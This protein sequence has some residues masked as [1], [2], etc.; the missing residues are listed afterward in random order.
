[1]RLD[2][3]VTQNVTLWKMS[4]NINFRMNN[5]VLP[6][7]LPVPISVKFK[8]KS[9]VSR[10]N[11]KMLAKRPK[12]CILLMMELLK[13]QKKLTLPKLF[14]P[15]HCAT[16]KLRPCRKFSD[17]KSLAHTPKLSSKNLETLFDQLKIG[18]LF[19]G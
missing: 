4:E 7:L 18:Q 11:G 3:L 6:L 9:A 8:L 17:A 2:L 5:K 12:N 16:P 19:F 10:V 14:W 1:M 13:L 15:L